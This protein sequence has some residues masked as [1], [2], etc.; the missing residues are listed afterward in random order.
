MT[1]S[2]LE[3]T[4][5]QITN[6]FEAMGATPLHTANVLATIT[7]LTQ[8]TEEV[9]GK[10]PDLERLKDKS[11][12]DNDRLWWEAVWDERRHQYKRAGLSHK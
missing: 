2:L 8:Y 12:S 11:Y 6:H 5:E 4:A 10:K 9:I 1:E 7:L 3:Q